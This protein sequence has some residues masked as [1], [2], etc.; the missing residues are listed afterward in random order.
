MKAIAKKFNCIVL[1]LLL[2]ISQL[3][4]IQAFNQWRFDESP[5]VQDD[6]QNQTGHF[7]SED[8]AS[9]HQDLFVLP[10]IEE[11]E[12]ESRHTN[13]KKILDDLIQSIHVTQWAITNQQLALQA[14]APTHEQF[15]SGNLQAWISVFRI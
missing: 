5:L 4:G 1:V 14:P 3:V 7:L 15:H 2:S 12:E 13:F 11:E 6:S 8:G 10:E 9:L